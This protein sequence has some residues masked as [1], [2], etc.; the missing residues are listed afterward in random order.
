M[1]TIECHNVWMMQA[2]QNIDL[3]FFVTVQPSQSFDGDMLDSDL[4]FFVM[5]PPS[6]DFAKVSSSKTVK[7]IIR[8]LGCDFDVLFEVYTPV[9]SKLIGLYKFTYKDT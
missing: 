3:S 1:M 7:S 8:E 9:H 2:R 6:V 4:A 5:I